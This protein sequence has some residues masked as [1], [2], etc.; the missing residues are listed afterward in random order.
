MLTPSKCVQLAKRMKLFDGLTPK[1]VAEVFDKGLTM[2]WKKGETIVHK[3][4]QADQMYVIVEGRVGVYNA[5]THLATLEAGEMF[6][7]MALL[8][9]GKRSATVVALDDSTILFALS[10]KTFHKLLT[11]HVAVQLL[12]NI[13]K[14]LSQRLCDANERLAREPGSEP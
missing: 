5:E 1:D 3:D 2:R 7:E 13:A 6:G 12:M 4:A 9:G 14:T 8:T 10:E 11:H